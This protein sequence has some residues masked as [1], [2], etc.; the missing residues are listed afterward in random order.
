[1]SLRVV[2][3]TRARVKPSRVMPAKGWATMILEPA[4]LTSPADT[5]GAGSLML[6]E[7]AEPSSVLNVNCIYSLILMGFPPLR[8]CW[9]SSAPILG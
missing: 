3:I 6:I 7:R 4:P 1:M 9:W 5:P 2:V 8:T